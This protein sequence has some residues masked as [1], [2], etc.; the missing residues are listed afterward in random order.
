M[1]SVPGDVHTS[2]VI[3]PG[4]FEN[5]LSEAHPTTSIRVGFVLVNDLADLVSLVFRDVNS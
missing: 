5:R 2:L 4:A 1:R 3:V